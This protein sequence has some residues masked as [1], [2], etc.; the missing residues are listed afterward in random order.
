VSTVSEPSKWNSDAAAL[1]KQFLSSKTGRLF[2]LH[3]DYMRPSL[4]LPTPTVEAMALQGRYVSGYEE[5]VS[6]ILSLTVPPTEDGT[7]PTMYPS[8]DDDSAWAEPPK[9]EE[10]PA[11]GPKPAPPKIAPIKKV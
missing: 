6:N 4:N 10:A 9:R 2:L 3:L 1:L 5:A 11:P 7:Q 8:L